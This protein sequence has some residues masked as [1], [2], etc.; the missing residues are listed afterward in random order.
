M[1]ALTLGT[2]GAA[3]WKVSSA[4]MCNYTI[5]KFLIYKITIFIKADYV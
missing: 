4:E 1:N 2:D 5:I 3:S